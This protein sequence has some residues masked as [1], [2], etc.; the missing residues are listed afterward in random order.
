MLTRAVRK[1]V[2]VLKHLPPRQ[3]KVCF[4]LGFCLFV[5]W[6]VGLFGFLFVFETGSHLKDN[7]LGLPN[8]RAG[9]KLKRRNLEPWQGQ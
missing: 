3:V 9:M 6:L 4:C 2:H 7:V 5:C 8:H 1:P